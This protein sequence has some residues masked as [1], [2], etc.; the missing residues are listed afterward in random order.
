MIWQKMTRYIPKIW[1]ITAQKLKTIPK[2]R[3][4]ND[5]TETNLSFAVKLTFC[6]TKT[7]N[8]YKSPSFEWFDGKQL[9]IYSQIDFLPHKKLI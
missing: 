5:L 1:N 6:R 7:Y 8:N 3:L 4:L 9:V 2:L